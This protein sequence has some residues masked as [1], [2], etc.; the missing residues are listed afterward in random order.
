MSDRDPLEQLARFGTGGAA[1]PLPPAEVRRLGD[2][3]RAR[4]TAVSAVAGVVAVVAVAIPLGLY[5]A[6]DDSARPLPPAGSP[7]A[8]S[9]SP[10]PARHMTIPEGFPL[11]HGLVP[12]SPADHLL[13]DVTGPTRTDLGILPID[14]CGPVTWSPQPG[15]RLDLTF[16]NA[17]I[18]ESRALALYA[19]AA[20][21]ARQVARF[22]DAVTRCPATAAATVTLRATALEA[23]HVTAWTRST[24]A[25][26]F[27]SAVVVAVGRAVLL[28]TS[29]GP[30]EGAHITADAGYRKQAE[31]EV[32]GAAAWLAPH[33]CTF[34]G[35]E[36]SV[37]KAS[38]T[39][40]NPTPTGPVF[41]PRGVDAL[42]LGMSAA[43][44]RATGAATTAARPAGNGWKHG[45][46]GLEYAFD[47]DGR[48]HGVDGRVS[49]T[50]GLEQLIATADM[51]T[52]GGVHVGSTRAE[53]EAGFG[54]LV[55]AGDEMTAPAGDGSWSYVIVLDHDRVVEL[56]LELPRQDCSS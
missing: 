6:H 35:H 54:H 4:R 1:S 15:D 18:E 55:G 53:V 43:E 48:S 41:G 42:V 47:Q 44:V 5:A 2:R 31:T 40:G 23:D 28:V 13:G 32:D 39:R 8:T 34:A 52:P 33:M 12:A 49:P 46:L 9:T 14:V 56:R 19:D 45:C 16:R 29:G 21:A 24:P 27:D 26:R 51:R 7:T 11:D 20:T 30:A 50:Q 22:R 25:G 36:C 37:P 38:A 17:S 10:A 3:R